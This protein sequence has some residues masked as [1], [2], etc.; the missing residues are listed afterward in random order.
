MLDHT[1]KRRLERLEG[2]SRV[3]LQ[4]VDPREIRILLDVDRVAAHGVDIRA[5]RELLEK[6]NFAVSAGQITDAG[7]RLSVRPRGEFT[8]LEDIENI[9]VDNR[10]LRLSDIASVE[11]RSPD[12]NYGRHLN[13]TYAV[14]INIFKQ[15][16]ANMVDVNDRLRCRA[17]RGYPRAP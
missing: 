12:R 15:T 13:R 7:Q 11:L 6:S 3:E 4:G 16:G 9:V 5:L 8:S 14:G 17:W 2:V 10:N 1:V